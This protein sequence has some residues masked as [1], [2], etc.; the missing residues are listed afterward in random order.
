MAART[1]PSRLSVAIAVAPVA[2][3]AAP[4][5]EVTATWTVAVVVAAAVTTMTEPE[6]PAAGR[7]LV[8]RELWNGPWSGRF[9]L[10]ARKT[11]ANQLAV[12]QP[13]I[14]VIG[15]R[16]FNIADVCC[17]RTLAS[18]QR[19]DATLDGGGGRSGGRGS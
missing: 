10:G 3:R 7:P 14:F 5:A 16:R 18:R 6:A 17:S 13:P 11:G 9:S 12:S 15:P 8:H 2:G 1:T 4:V 19:V